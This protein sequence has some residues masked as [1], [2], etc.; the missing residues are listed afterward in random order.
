VGGSDNNTWKKKSRRSGSASDLSLEK[1]KPAK[2]V[3]KKE[4]REHRVERSASN[5]SLT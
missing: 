1:E 3:A 5:R 4:K 2:S